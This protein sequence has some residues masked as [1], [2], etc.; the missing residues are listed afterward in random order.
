MLADPDR[1]NQSPQHSQAV[2]QADVVAFLGLLP[3]EFAGDS[4]SENCRY[5]EHRCSHGSSLGRAMHGLVA[6]RLGA[7]DASLCFFM[8]T[9]DIDLSDTKVA[10][11]G[12]VHI[13]AL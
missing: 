10:T 6:A 2:K 4:G 7:T 11:D 3:E 9:A 13:A 5:Y 8:E 1:S 12:G